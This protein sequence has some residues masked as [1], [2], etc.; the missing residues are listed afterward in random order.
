VHGFFGGDESFKNNNKIYFDNYLS[1]EVKAKYDFDYTFT[2]YS[3][4]NYFKLDKKLLLLRYIP[5]FQKYISP[6]YNNTIDDIANALYNRYKLKIDR[7]KTVSFI[8]HSMGGIIAK[9][10][11]LDMCK[12]AI[13]FKGKYI[14][15]ATPHK[16]ASI[17]GCIKKL[18]SQAIEIEQNSA[19]INSLSKDW[20]VYKN[21]ITRQYYCG[22]GDSIVDCKTA[23][24]DD[25]EMHQITIANEDHNS[26]SKPNKTK[27]DLIQTLN[28]FLIS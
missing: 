9:K 14:S 20:D 2:Y 1:E 18:N 12:K 5:I 16:G 21:R 24:P 8:G 10:T 13:E 28:K 17:N 19:L 25:S 23:F 27:S 4:N 7:Y 3:K 26:I 11:I 6:G 22:S 15:L